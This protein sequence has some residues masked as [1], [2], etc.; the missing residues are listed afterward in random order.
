MVFEWDPSKSQT[1]KEKHGI[2]F[3]AA[4]ALW[5][6]PDRLEILA[7]DPIENRTILIGVIHRQLWTAIYAVRGRAV[8]IISVRRSRKKEKALYEKEKFGTK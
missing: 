2:D 7:P 1:N 4:K 5:E 3:E 8:R 6:D